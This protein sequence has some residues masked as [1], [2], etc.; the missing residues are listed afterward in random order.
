MKKSVLLTTLL[1]LAALNAFS[2]QQI[3]EKEGFVLKW[4][5]QGENLLIT[6]KAETTGWI[7]FGIGATRMMKDANMILCWVDDASGIAMA[8]DHFGIGLTSHKNDISLGG[9]QNVTVLS[10]SQNET[11]TEVTF[12]I[13]L[14][15]GDEFD[16][17]LVR[18]ESYRILLASNNSD[19]I[20]WKHNNR[21]AQEIII[22]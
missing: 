8:E 16:K 7:G 12:T 11:T 15:S 18:G 20:S 3:L 9:K 5:S 10:G 17:P 4:E 13:P 1:L 6:V 19:N 14:D 2:Q 22:R 21:Y